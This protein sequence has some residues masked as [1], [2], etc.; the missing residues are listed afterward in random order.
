MH[1]TDVPVV[2]ETPGVGEVEEVVLDV[3]LDDPLHYGS[4]GCAGH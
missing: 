2:T 1:G 3:D 4:V